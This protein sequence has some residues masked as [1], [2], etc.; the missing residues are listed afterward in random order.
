MSHYN[1]SMTSV[2]LLVFYVLSVLII[3]QTRSSSNLLNNIEDMVKAPDYKFLIKSLRMSHYR[4]AIVLVNTQL[5]GAADFLRNNFSSFMF[6]SQM[7]IRIMNGHVD[8][9]RD[10]SSKL[11]YV[12]IFVE[13]FQ[14]IL[15]TLDTFVQRPQVAYSLPKYFIYVTSS[16]QPA[17]K[18]LK[19]TMQLIW[20]NMR[21]LHYV[22]VFTQHKDAAFSYNPFRK[23][24]K[25]VTQKQTRIFSTKVTDLNGYK[26]KLSVVVGEPVEGEVIDNKCVKGN[27]CILVNC[28]LRYLNASY[29]MPILDG[30]I[31][32]LYRSSKQAL[33][34]REIDLSV[35]SHW[36]LE[37][38]LMYSAFPIQ[39]SAVVG[40][41]R[42]SRPKP[43]FSSVFSFF[44]IYVWVLIV[45]SN[46]LFTLLLNSG[47]YLYLKNYI[48]A[49][50][51][52][53]T[54]NIILLSHYVFEIV[55]ETAFQGA[56]IT[57]LTTPVF[58][59]NID[60]VEDL[61]ESGLPLYGEDDWRSLVTEKLEL[62]QMSYIDVG[63]SLWAMKTDK[64]Y[65]S[66]DYWAELQLLNKTADGTY[67]SQFYHIIKEPLGM[68]KITFL[69]A[70]NYPFQ[71]TFNDIVMKMHDHGLFLWF[72]KRRFNFKDERL[73][74][75]LSFK[76]IYGA[77]LLLVVGLGMATLIFFIELVWFY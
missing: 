25:I 66:T 18:T 24:L 49:G 28:F 15:K 14:D 34:N 54:F 70:R 67:Y 29:E 39:Q 26:I 59:K 12:H 45:F 52:L 38:Y 41:V 32:K 7:P 62:K 13:E 3:N 44:D 4:N 76:N 36:L 2:S 35:A 17:I 69:L 40:L 73:F 1:N 63:R 5:K 46:I 30:G 33:K 68:G 21:I 27:L 71:H 64:V 19:S 47:L 6:S 37:E 58:D 9:F 55:F 51:K 57:A 74:Q 61:V 48:S 22:I 42:K 43:L 10:K 31:E 16:N 8:E 65:L 77:F 23:E 11:E 53:S 72:G 20:I 56:V 50:Q 75:K 60:T